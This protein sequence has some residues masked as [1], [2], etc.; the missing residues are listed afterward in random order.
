MFLVNLEEVWDGNRHFI[1]TPNQISFLFCDLL[2]N[3]HRLLVEF[4]GFLDWVGNLGESFAFKTVA[5]SF[6][7]DLNL[8]GNGYFT[9]NEF[10]V[11][12]YNGHNMPLYNILLFVV[13]GD[14]H[15]TAL[16]NLVRLEFVVGEEFVCGNG[17]V[18]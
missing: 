5:E 6:F 16:L 17:P 9:R 7:L 11:F 2:V 3:S 13:N 14:S 1:R 18:V 10:N 4:D 12:Y 15:M 8:I